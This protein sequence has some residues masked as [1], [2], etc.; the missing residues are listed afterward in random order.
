MSRTSKTTI[1]SIKVT[2]L[3]DGERTLPLEAIKNLSD[4]DSD[5]LRNAL[6]DFA[7]GF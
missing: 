2:A 6:G 3:Q 4:E 7:K 5:Q 1:G